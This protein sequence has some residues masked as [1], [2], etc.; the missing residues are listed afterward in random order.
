[1]DHLIVIHGFERRELNRRRELCLQRRRLRDN[2]NPFELPEV[3]FI[4]LFRFP[5][6]CTQHI[7][8]ILEPYL[9]YGVRKHVY[10]LI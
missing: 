9:G 10:L 2:F 7:I 6:F 8:E 5:Q 3:S 4:E 1:M